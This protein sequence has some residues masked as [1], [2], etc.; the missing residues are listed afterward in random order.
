MKLNRKC[1]DFTRY[2]NKSEFPHIDESAVL[3]HYLCLLYFIAIILIPHEETKT[4]AW[5][6]EVLCI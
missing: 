4:N 2:E 1:K 6:H 5:W 3:K